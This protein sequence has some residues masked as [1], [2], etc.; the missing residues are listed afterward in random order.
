MFQVIVGPPPVGLG[1]RTDLDCPV[2]GKGFS[3]R[4]LLERHTRIHWEEK[5]FVCNVCGYR[6]NRRDNLNSHLKHKHKLV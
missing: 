4:W 6:S 5:R 2:C 3:A 1:W